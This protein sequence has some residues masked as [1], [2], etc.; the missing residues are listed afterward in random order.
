M[1]FLS[2]IRIFLVLDGKSSQGYP[3]NARF[4]QCSITGPTIF[5]LYIND[6]PD[7]VIYYIA[8][9]ADDTTLYCDQASNQWKQLE[10]TAELEFDL[11]GTVD[12]GRKRLVD[13]NIE[14]TSS[15]SFF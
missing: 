15:S 3:I 4:R 9:Y 6:L 2:N 1:H 13:F 5:L 14:K 12:W 10:M 11:R 8:I 7:D